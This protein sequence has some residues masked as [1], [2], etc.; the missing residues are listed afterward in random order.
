MEPAAATGWVTKEM[1]SARAAADFDA[2]VRE[3]W[4]RVFRFILVSL[5]DRNDAE[6]LTQDCFLKAF[7]AWRNFRGDSSI[8]TWLMRIAVNQLRDHSRNRRLQ[9]WKRT[10][11]AGSTAEWPVADLRSSPEDDAVTKQ[12]VEAVWRAATNLPQQQR[13]VFLLRFVEDMDLLE[14]AAATGLKEGTV[15]THLFRALQAVREQT[16]GVR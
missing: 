16:G 10:R 8:N 12:Q 1:E 2:V 5:R 6:S 15:K 14:I 13:T 9:F 4:P 3:Y 11:T 7:R